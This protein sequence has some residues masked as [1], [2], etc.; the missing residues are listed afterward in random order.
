MTAHEL[1]R[2]LLSQPDEDVEAWDPNV[3]FWRPVTGAVY[4]TGVAWRLQ[5]DS[6]DEAILDGLC[7]LHGGDGLPETCRECHPK[8]S[9][10]G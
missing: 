5:T 8:D 3:G 10:N 6:D 7:R 2:L 9:S 4:G 1:A